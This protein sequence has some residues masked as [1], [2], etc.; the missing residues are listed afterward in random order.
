MKHPRLGLKLARV[1]VDN[2]LGDIPARQGALNQKHS[3]YQCCGFCLSTP[4]FVFELILTSLVYGKACAARSNKTKYSE[5]EAQVTRTH[6]QIVRAGQWADRSGE[7]VCQLACSLLN[8]L[9]L[10][11]HG[12][13]V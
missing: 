9:S 8:Y 7:E 3:G 10:V 6:E 1:I 4:L 12:V 2:G 5:T 13:F 11:A